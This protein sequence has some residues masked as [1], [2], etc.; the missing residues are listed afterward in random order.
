MRVASVFVVIGLL[1]GPWP[2][3]V[4]V[5]RV[6]YDFDRDWKLSRGDHQNAADRGF[7]DSAWKA[8]TLPRA[9]NEDDAFRVDIT[10]LPTGVAW[11]R[12]QFVL[13]PGAA[14]AKVLLEFEGVRQAAEVFLNGE[15]I[16]LHEDG[17]TPF[18]FDISARVRPAPEVNVVAV[19][20]DNAWDYRERSTNQR[21][22]WNDRNF[23]ANYGGI[24]KHVRLHVADPLHQTLPL[25]NGLGTTG[26]YVT[27]SEFD[28]PA[29]AALIR[30]EAEVRND[31]SEPRVVGFEAIVTDLEGREVGRFE[32]PES[33]TIPAGGDAVLTAE[34]KAHGLQWWTW[35]RGHLYDVTTQLVV[36]GRVV[37][38]VTTRT[39]FRQTRFGRGRVELNGRTLHLKGYAQR[40]TNEWPALGPCVPAWVSDF[41]N[42]LMVESG[43]NLVR[44]MH[45]APWRQDVESCDRVGLMQ[46]MP[47]GDSERDVT[48]RRWEQRVEVMRASIVANRNNPSILFYESGNNGV[49]EEHMT[50]MRRL[51]DTLDPRGGRA[52][53]SRDMLGSAVAEYGGEMLYINKSG[54][55]PMW[56]TEYSRDE[57][58]RKYWD[59]FSPPFHKDGDGPPH[60][61]EPAPS[62]NRNQDSHAIENVRRWYDYWRERPG[63]GDR[64][65]AGGVNIVFSDSNTHHRGAEN[66]R[67]SGEVDAMRLPKDGFH[68]HR[69]MWDGWVD[70]EHPRL[71]LIGHW[72]YA[73]GVTKP[74]HVVSNADVVELFLDGVRRGR[75][76]SPEHRFLFTFPDVDWKPGVLEAVG[77]DRSGR[78]V[79]RDRRETT[80]PSA[81]VR[82]V[83]HTAGGGLRA[84]AAD[85]ALID[86][87]V[88]DR[89]GRRVPTALDAVTFTID[90]PA[91]WRGGIAQGPENLIGA[92]TIPVE[93]G[94]N[95]VM[96]R[97]TTSSGRVTIRA[98]AEGLAP[99]MIE[100][101]AVKADGPLAA[102]VHP[103]PPIPAIVF[104]R[105]EP[106]AGPSEQ[107]T[108]VPVAIMSA[109]AGGNAD[110]IALAYDD[111][112]ETTW[113]SDGGQGTAWAEFTL[114][115]PATLTELTLKMPGWRTKTYP[116]AVSVD[117][118]RVYQGITPVSLGYVTL[119]LRPVQGRVVRVQL[120]GRERADETFGGITEVADAANAADGATVAKGTLG[121]VEVELYEPRH[122]PAA[123]IDVWPGGTMPGNGAREPEADLP[124][125]G[126]GV[127]RITNVSRPTLALY[128]V[129]GKATVSPVLV[130]CPGGGYS[131]VT[132]NKEGEAVAA[133]LNSHG[134][135]AAVLKYRTPN[136]RE[137]ALQDL[138]RSISL[139]R[140]RAAEWRL[141]P[142]RIGAIGF[143]AGGNMVAKANARGDERVSAAIDEIDHARCGPDVAVLVYPAYLGKDGEVADDVRPHAAMKPTL[144]VHSDDDRSFVPGTRLYAAAL[145]AAHAPHEMLLYPTG[146]H[147]Y[148]L[149][150][151]RAA[152]AWPD[153][154]ITW[155]RASGILP[156]SEVPSE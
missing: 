14:G 106:P 29:G 44:W 41:S 36:D 43:G 23:F 78:E 37:D 124:S 63:T 3:A 5:E 130:V 60:K 69:V 114:V 84:D 82:L 42:G 54:R 35:G 12:K 19:R 8:V 38:A 132:F 80:G 58:L 156:Q 142:N 86:V 51:R 113:K 87:E 108:R 126:D 71:H 9:W 67:R 119:P 34:G 1:V 139:L 138:Q 25:V 64:V 27:A 6:T 79:C 39:G 73:E 135:A 94:V 128:P 48:G 98:A 83:P 125:R 134:I 117:G 30:A 18:G 66:Y 100:L 91:E 97:S 141:D 20:T 151:T 127:R 61:G 144:I 105:S 123:T 7:D 112:E 10:E 15:A 111:N 59:E 28:L 143:S 118:R 77:Y 26:V 46:A 89:K 110:T 131:Y 4:A 146:G 22:Q 53:G 74:V 120:I 21:Y 150:C 65:N 24:T 154:C 17:I 32:A 140:S 88:V 137:G 101:D 76:E 85:C 129:A 31:R 55:K 33:V 47:A 45:V 72:N 103:L 109:T 102:G 56:A 90:G 68:A 70:A 104:R 116:I 95:R 147:G 149:T 11:Y 52:I 153:A 121:I 96:V 2:A 57:G 155:F 122:D 16:G 92:A 81:A 145:A 50:E 62:Y 13:P 152:R 40:T 148:G 99:A 75:R 107:A 115:R 49:S 93:C 136:N 133:W